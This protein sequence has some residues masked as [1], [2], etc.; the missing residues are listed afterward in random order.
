M[1][2]KKY[3]VLMSFCAVAGFS[4]P[5]VTGCPTLTAASFKIEKLYSGKQDTS[6]H[7]PIALETVSDGAGGVNIFFTLRAGKVL[8]YREAT[9]AVT[10]VL[11]IPEVKIENDPDQ[12]RYGFEDGLE[13]VAVDRNF[14]SN[15]FVYFYY[16][17]YVNPIV[18]G[19]TQ[20]FQVA[21]Y[22]FN[23]QILVPASRALI[24]QFPMRSM[25]LHNGGGMDFDE[26]G[27]LW[28]GTGDDNQNQRS[29]GCTAD[30]RGS[31]LR[32]HPKTDYPEGANTPGIGIS[33]TVPSGN[34]GEY[35]SKN[36]FPTFSD[37]ALVR[38][39]VYAKGI[40]QGYSVTAHPTKHWVAWGEC[41]PDIGGNTEEHNLITEPF[42]GGYPYF[43]GN[44]ITVNYATLAESPRN[45]D[46]ECKGAKILPP[47]KPAIHSYARACAM[48]GP[49]FTFNPSRSLPG[50]GLPPNF[51]DQWLMMD[52]NRNTIDLSKVS[53][54]GKSITIE[55]DPWKYSATSDRPEPLVARQGP[56][57]AIYIL[58]YGFD[59][60]A[61]RP[62]KKASPNGGI[63]RIS[64]IGPAWDAACVRAVGVDP[65][66][67]KKDPVSVDLNNLAIRS[68][69]AGHFD[70]TG[71]GEWD[72]ELYHANGTLVKKLKISQGVFEVAQ[73]TTGIYKAHIKNSR[74]SKWTSVVVY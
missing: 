52:I 73:L 46:A 30:L 31:I 45:T 22:T 19:A 65:T 43:S 68:I 38:P 49:I 47:A 57:G 14:A 69:G 12:A 23:G 16:A 72:L 50:R 21:R 11:D 42:F 33:Y 58:D 54:D 32:I 35:F 53:A 61:T 41:G 44:N 48:T 1:S 25:E 39:E 40:R 29:S 60:W 4:F 5:A 70:F 56:D 59:W 36:G 24:L 28:I 51:H 66:G 71:V 15:H 74:Q 37:P 13:G 27:D 2:F 67:I 64:Y 55:A 20:Y 3:F 26:H 7:E 63:T 62:G 18:G 17:A 8:L 9:K 6:L 10:E 34:F